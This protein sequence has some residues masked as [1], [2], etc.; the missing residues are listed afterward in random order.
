MAFQIS[1]ESCNAAN[2]T[3][4]TITFIAMGVFCMICRR[5]VDCY[6]PDKRTSTTS[7]IHCFP[8]LHLKVPVTLI[9]NFVRD[10]QT[11]VSTA[12][13]SKEIQRG[14]R[15]P[16]TLSLMRLMLP[17]NAGRKVFPQVDRRTVWRRLP[18]SDRGCRNG[19]GG[20]AD[21]T[22]K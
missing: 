6:D 5:D 15:G 16:S 18:W 20:T 7:C 13:G 21:F 8:G 19:I 9:W 14:L 12:G 2:F 3:T 22:H 1:S 4:Y 11:I 17:T 10:Q